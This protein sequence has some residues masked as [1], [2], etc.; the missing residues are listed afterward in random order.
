MLGQK[1]LPSLRQSCL[2]DSAFY[3]LATTVAIIFRD[4][5]VNIII[6]TII[7]MV[8]KKMVTDTDNKY[9]HSFTI[10]ASISAHVEVNLGR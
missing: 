10:I 2:T 6:I 1:P 3:P 9:L 4:L 7:I 5:V 8:K